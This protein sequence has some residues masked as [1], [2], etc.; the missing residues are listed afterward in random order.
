MSYKTLKVYLSGI[1]LAHIERGMADPTKSTSLHLVCRGIH[2]Q[3]GDNQRT[4]LPIT[5]NL[6]RVLKEQLRIST[7]Y[8]ILEQRM[9]WALF[10]V[11]FYGFFRASEL[12]PSLCWST[13]TLSSTQ[14]SI[15]LV[16][17]KTDPFRRGSTIHLFPTG[18]STCPIKAMTAY[19]MY[20]DTSSNNPVF[21]AG[22]F[23]PLTQKKLNRT[24][25]N[26]L[27]QGGFN[28]INYSSHSFRIGAATTA[29]AAGLPPWLIKRL[30]RWHSDAYLTYLR[31]PDSVLSSVP[32]VLASTDASHQPPWDPDL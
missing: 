11:A 23:N 7:F 10:T 29:A 21:K 18:S 4:R 25:R 30:G 8:T 13:I 22:R 20:V 2:R 19:A 12:I 16:Q 17:S 6:L 28:H 24:L 32:L 9:L 31:C 1:R 5:I 27:Q 15:T 3:Q 14:M 26:L